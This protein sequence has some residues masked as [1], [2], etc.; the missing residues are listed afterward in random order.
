MAASRAD[1]TTRPSPLKEIILYFLKLGILGFGGPLAMMA[2]FQRDL[3]EKRGWATREQFTRALALIKALPGPTGTQVAIYLGYCR[4]GRLGGF[5]AGACL[6]FPAFVLMILLGSFY[7]SATELAWSRAVLFGMSAA[8]LG[9]ISDSVW[10]LT[11]PYRAERAFWVVAVAAAAITWFKPAAEPVVILG[12]GALGMGLMRFWERGKS[13][14]AAALF[15]SALV[16]GSSGLSVPLLAQLSG[17]MLKAGAFVFGTGLAIVPMLAHD[18]VERYGWLDDQQFLDALAFGQVT[19]GPVVITSTFIGFKVAGLLGAVVGT[20]SIFAPAFFNMLT[21]FPGA[22]KK[23]GASPYT[24]RFVMWAV[25]AVV[26][27]I[28]AVTVRL[29]VAAPPTHALWLWIVLALGSLTVSV[30]TKVP[31]WATIPV[32]GIVAAIVAGLTS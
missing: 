14:A 32:A 19:P 1:S 24:R 28:A 7:A 8:A 12:A 13:M 16:F 30:F 21:W 9:V 3:V 10:R 2:A 27:S 31:A 17:V 20:A 23:L 29:G 22:E 15:P 4:G 18:V 6:I 11:G 26:G 5:L 25:G